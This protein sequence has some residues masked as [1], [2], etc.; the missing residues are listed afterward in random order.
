MSPRRRWT[1]WR[2]RR[3]A[4]A[5]VARRRRGRRA[6]SAK[7]GSR[8]P[9]G[10]EGLLVAQCGVA[11]TRIRCRSASSAS[12]RTSWW[13]W[14]RPPRPARRV[15]AG[16]GLVDDHELGAG[17]EELVAAPVGLDE[18]GRDDDDA[19]S[20]RRATRRRRRPRSSR[21]AVPA[22]TSSASRWNLSRSS[23]CHCS[24]RCG[25][26]STASRCDLAPVEQLARDRAAPRPSCRCRR[27]R[28]SAAGPGRACSAISSGTSWYG[29]GSTAIAP[30]ERNGPG[31]RAEAEP[32][33]VAEQPRRA[34]VAEVASGSGRSK[35]RRLDRLRA[36][37]RSPRSRRRCRRAGGGRA[38]SSVDSGRT[39]HS[40][41][42]AVTSEPTAKRHASPPEDARD[43]WRRSAAQS[44]SSWPKRMTV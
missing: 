15:G 10:A 19:G 20:A 31:A 23:A 29:R 44:S 16:V 2:A 36:A 28:R 13:R 22:R 30:K 33:R 8:K 9:R 27:R 11:V 32:E 12:P 14:W 26:Q 21:A 37:G 24:A 17:A 7:S 41:P 4:L 18:V 35:R 25:G 38:R 39:T 34:V 43:S 1:R 5:L 3:S 40:R 6:A 42:R